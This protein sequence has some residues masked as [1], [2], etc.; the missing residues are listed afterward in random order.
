MFIIACRL[1]VGLGLGLGLGLVV[2]RT[3]F[4]A[5]LGFNC[6][7]TQPNDAQN[8]R[9]FFCKRCKEIWPDLVVLRLCILVSVY[10]DSFS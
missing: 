2:M 9:Y 5:T 3:Y 10:L 1:V 4:C 6:H 7:G 8:V